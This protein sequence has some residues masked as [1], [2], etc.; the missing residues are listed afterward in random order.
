MSLPQSFS[1]SQRSQQAR[2][3]SSNFDTP[4]FDQATAYP[5]QYYQHQHQYQND[6]G[7]RSDVEKT[8]DSVREEPQRQALSPFFVLV[9]DV[10]TQEFHHPTVHYIFSDDDDAIV[11]EAAVRSAEEREGIS[12]ASHHVSD[13]ATNLRK[14]DHPHDNLVDDEETHED[15]NA[16]S[17]LLPAPTP[18]V[19]EHY[20]I[21]DVAPSTNMSAEADRDPDSISATAQHTSSHSQRPFTKPRGP[22]TQSFSSR[23]NEPDFRFRVTSAKS[24]S[25]T[26]QILD[27]RLSTAPT[28]ASDDDG[29]TT[30]ATSAET[31]DRNV[32]LQIH[33]T[34]GISFEE[35]KRSKENPNENMN[36][37]DL[38]LEEMMT[39]LKLRMEELNQVVEMAGHEES[40]SDEQK[41][42]VSGIEFAR[43]S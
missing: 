18:G 15:Q 31:D 40:V 43:I 4:H 6:S 11:T 29:P 35:Y 42:G 22:E 12:A 8:D 16:R 28:L 26:F 19:Q 21:L 32:M 14:Q 41:D 3:S 20:I 27:T 25:P 7:G 39:Q 30:A 24:L 17:C 5:R 36:T 1:T 37:K 10:K 38:S 33:G 13:P 9:K 2:P 34:P 23:R